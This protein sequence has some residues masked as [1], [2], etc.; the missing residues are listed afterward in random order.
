[1]FP[2]FILVFPDVDKSLKVTAP[3]RSIVPEYSLF[4]TFST[5]LALLPGMPFET[6]MVI[7]SAISIA[8]LALL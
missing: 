2:P 1:M 4:P 3:V 7:P 6:L 5:I 8:L